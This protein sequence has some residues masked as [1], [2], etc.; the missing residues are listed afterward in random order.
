MSK[1]IILCEKPK[2]LEKIIT[3][4]EKYILCDAIPDNSHDVIFVSRSTCI[5]EGD[6]DMIAN[7]LET[8]KV[9]I[10]TSQK[11][12][13]LKK[14]IYAFFGASHGENCRGI[15]GIP[16]EYLSD[17]EPTSKMRAIRIIKNAEIKKLPLLELP[18]SKSEIRGKFGNFVGDL[19]ALFL[20]SE[21]LKFLFSSGV[22]FVIDYVLLMLLNNYINIG[23]GTMEISALIAWCVSS[24]TNFFLNRMFVFRSNA[25]FWP[26]FAEYYGLAGGVFV[27]KTYVLLEVLTRVLHINLPIAKLI[28]E[29][30]FFISN[31]FV[32]KFFIF[33]KKKDKT[34]QA[35]NTPELPKET[36]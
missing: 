24:L 28:A 21:P 16:K 9:I 30:V 34:K 29:V 25:P 1:Y 18:L 36:E 6:L 22:A 10:G 35:K 4:T 33:K 8:K 31:Y 15:V 32:Q 27:L 20:V 3:N 23:I 19:S 17:L 11:K 26:S 2:K 12:S 13:G 7:M 14:F 5:T